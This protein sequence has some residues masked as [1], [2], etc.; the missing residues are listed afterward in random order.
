MNDFKGLRD[1][2]EELVWIH[3]DLQ[4]KIEG[5]EEEILRL[6]EEIKQK[7]ETQCNEEGS[8]EAKR[9]GGNR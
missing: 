5:V 9:S 8:E 6:E 3:H 2:Q 1:I 4:E 7:E